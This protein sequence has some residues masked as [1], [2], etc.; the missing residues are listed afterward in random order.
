[1]I[2]PAGG[3][4]LATAGANLAAR[5]AVE[6]RS[7]AEVADDFQSPIVA[8]RVAAQDELLRRAS[9]GDSQAATARREIAELAAAATKETGR[10]ARQT[11]LL[12][13]LGRIAADDTAGDA[14]FTRLLESK[15]A[16]SSETTRI[17]AVRILA[18]RVAGRAADA[19][20][21][22]EC[23]LT[24]LADRT[25]RVR[26]AALLAAAHVA[27]RVAVPAIID[28]AADETDRL[29]HYAAWTTLR[30]LMPADE[31]RGLLADGRA[32]VRLAALLALH[33]LGRLDGPEV[34]ALAT[35]ADARVSQTA[36]TWLA[37]TGY[38]L[39]DP[40]AVLATIRRLDNRHVDYRLRLNILRKLEGKAIDGSLRA[41]L[42]QISVN[43]WR[44]ATLQTDEVVP[45]EKSQEIAAVLWAVKPDRRTTETAWQLL[46][47]GWPML[48]DS[49]A[50]GF[51]KLGDDG[52]AVLAEKLPTADPARR[53]RG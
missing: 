6:Q 42:E 16:A 13:T 30:D 26:F 41:G 4:S 43:A 38:G 33:D 3:P 40:A 7:V 18:H 45:Q 12:W 46:G 9:G 28:A 49:V 10:E 31:L 1:R 19:R 14:F 35:D 47:H 17:Q 36:T 11:W 53:D 39:D 32:G 27:D 23:L 44:G 15:D 51:S 21:L 2:T 34:A 37:N 24:A 5:P 20:R 52:L 29:V 22:P 50:A 25:P 48:A 8:I